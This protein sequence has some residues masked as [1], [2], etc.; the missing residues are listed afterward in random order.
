MGYI[1][2][3]MLGRVVGPIAQDWFEYKTETGREF[4]KNKLE[5]Q[6]KI[7]QIDLENKFLLSE[8]DHQQKLKEMRCQFDINKEKA[9]HQMLLSYSDW[10]QKTFWDKC[11]PLRNPFE[12][13][14]GYEPEY[15]GNTNRLSSC[16][17]TTI[18][19]PNDKH[20]VPLRVISALKDNV[21]ENASTINANLSMFL[22][23]NY[24]VNGEHAIVSDI[25]S[26]KD[27]VPVNDAF[28]NYLYKGLRGQPT[29]VWTPSYTNGGT[30]VR[31]KLWSWG[32]GE[33]QAYPVGIDCGWIDLDIIYR[34]ALMDEVKSFQKAIEKI[35][36]TLPN[37]DIDRNIKILSMI[38]DHKENLTD[39]DFNRLLLLLS[40]PKEV[41]RQV[42][43]RVNE[44][45]S[46]IFSCAVAL[47]ADGYHL[48]EYGTMPQLPY[49]LPQM[50]L[51]KEFLL[52]IRDYYISLINT[53]LIEGI[54]TVDQAIEIELDLAEG[55]QLAHGDK[56]II[57][58]ICDD[59]R[60]LNEHTSGDIH[61]NT[62]QRLR[63][64]SNTKLLLQ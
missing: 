19:L 23:S 45:T 56:Q 11:F 52:T 41:K 47:Y 2:G 9:E 16:K 59:V 61:K 33:Q 28:I 22:M 64:V 12:V 13:P 39:E 51:P 30:I 60:L 37:K 3:G 29:I 6:K 63:K 26:W 50:N 34:R 42:Q 62:I 8:H 46:N 24:S 38:D 27:E 21:H 7:S 4:A 44:L 48:H 49:I 32:L 5:K 43:I 14:M 58:P 40:E 55:I 54:L 1:I 17:L 25:G 36:A 18:A 35:N 20:I 53:E 57:S 31:M 10:Q 15:D